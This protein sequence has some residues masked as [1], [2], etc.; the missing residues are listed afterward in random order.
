MSVTVPS[1][2]LPESVAWIALPVVL[3][4]LS[5]GV[6]LA[7]GRAPRGERRSTASLLVT[8]EPDPALQQTVTALR[9]MGATITRYDVE[10]GTLEARVPASQGAGAVRVQAA[11]DGE[12]LTRLSLEADAI[13]A[14]AI[15][16]GL[17]RELARPEL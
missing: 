16:R 4:M 17:R 8:G 7:L 2:T 11:A 6:R 3:V 10:A 9:R 12:Q 5:L 1:V 15:K 14:R 13:S